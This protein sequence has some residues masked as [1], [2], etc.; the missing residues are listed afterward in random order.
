VN[1]LLELR[2]I[3]VRKGATLIARVP[4]L[5]VREGEVLAIIGPNGAGKSTLLRVM[6]ALERPTEGAL[7]FR[8]STVEWRGSRLALRRRMAT[9]FAE[10]LLADTTVLANIALGCRFRKLPAEVIQHRTQRWM[11][12]LS[13]ARL[14]HR[15][16]RSL[17]SGEAQ[18]VSL[19]RALVLE[20]ELLLLD[21]PFASLDQP[22]RES[23]LLDLESILRSERM[24]A[25]FVT[26]DRTEALLLGDRLAVMMEGRILQVDEPSRLFRAPVSPEVARFVGAET[27]LQGTVISREQ[28]LLTIEVGG[29]KL[30]VAGEADVGEE[31]RLCFRPEDFTIARAE[32]AP[33][34]SSARNHLPG[35]VTHLAPLGALVRVT[36]D[37]SVPL[38]AH[39]T[40]ASAEELE[41]AEGTPVVVTFKATSV[42][43]L[44]HR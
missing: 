5:A 42:H 43:L 22:T 19:A 2:E 14:A 10:P 6:G 20:P 32:S 3:V 39:V 24:T 11:E 12:R 8:G 26:H 33:S 34:A 36:V 9:V 44:R 30:S 23:L 31:V 25:V 18:R 17:S 41:L 35:R 37:C 15:Q 13:I 4:Q 29:H 21:E 7:L 38:V 1:S 40:R 16:A 27:I 28:G